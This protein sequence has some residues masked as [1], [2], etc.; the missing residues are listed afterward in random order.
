[1]FIPNVQKLEFK[2]SADIY[3]YIYEDAEVLNPILAEKIKAKGDCQ[4]QMF[5]QI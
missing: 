4:Y 5:K 3:T 2:E 1:M